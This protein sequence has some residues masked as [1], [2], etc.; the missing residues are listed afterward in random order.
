MGAAAVEMAVVLPLFFMI[1]FG[2][3]EFGRAM[4]ALQIITNSAREGARACAVRPL[5]ESEVEDIC[6]EYAEACG[7]NGITVDVVPDPTTVTRGDPVE[8]KV[9]VKFTDVSWLP[10]FWNRDTILSSAST[11][12]KEREFD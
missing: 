5:T 2:I 7:V 6:V 4:M 1:I 10:P 12:R 3:V 8:V 9:E 11:M